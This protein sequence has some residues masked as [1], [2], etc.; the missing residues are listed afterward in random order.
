[1]P[2]RTLDPVEQPSLIKIEL[3]THA[4][5]AVNQSQA[6]RARAD[7]SRAGHKADSGGRQERWI[8]NGRVAESLS[9][10]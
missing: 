6:L 7:L 3:H 5:L 2:R 4:G 8:D 10:P 1:V 9:K